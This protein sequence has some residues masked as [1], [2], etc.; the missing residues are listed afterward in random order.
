METKVSAQ[1]FSG[2]YWRA[3][4]THEIMYLMSGPAHLPYLLVSLA[5]LREHYKGRVVVHGWPE[6]FEYLERYFNDPAIGV[7]VLCA[8]PHY[9][10]KNAQFYHKLCLMQRP[11]VTARL[12]LDADTTIHTDPAPLIE[13][14]AY[15]GL[16]ATQFHGWYTQSRVVRNRVERLKHVAEIPNEEI[17]HVLTNSY[18]SPNGGIWAARPESTALEQWREWTWA[19]RHWFIADECVLHVLQ[20]HCRNSMTVVQDERWNCSHKWCKE[21]AKIWHHHGDSNV[22]PDKSQRACEQW[23]PLWNRCKELNLA[24]CN[25]WRH[26]VGNRYLNHLER[27][28]T[29]TNVASDFK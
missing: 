3:R 19:A 9:R 21:G 28:G 16:V 10:G 27:E 11:G 24:N 12:Y 7:D 25:D 2:N 23:W 29:F 17:E 6:S 1:Y 18:P 13:Q 4:M 8:D 15:S 5:T 20:H 26:K 14:A 22:R